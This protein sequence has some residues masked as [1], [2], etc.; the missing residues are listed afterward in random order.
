MVL[1]SCVN[2]TEHFL[3]IHIF[4]GKSVLHGL[5]LIVTFNGQYSLE[6]KLVF[7]F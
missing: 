7:S 4:C 3:H 2:G 5:C 6:S 1:G